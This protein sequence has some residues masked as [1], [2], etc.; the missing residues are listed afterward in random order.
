M[1]IEITKSTMKKLTL[2]VLAIFVFII[3]YSTIFAQDKKS[4]GSASS[5]E[6]LESKKE[7]SYFSLVKNL[8]ETKNIDPDQ[9]EVDLDAFIQKEKLKLQ[10]LKVPQDKQD[11]YFSTL[12]KLL[13]QAKT[14][15]Q[16][17]KELDIQI[18]KSPASFKFQDLEKKISDINVT[19]KERNLDQT[20]PLKI[21]DIVKAY[22]P[23]YMPTINDILSDETEVV[24]NQKIIALAKHLDHNPVNIFNWLR[25][26]I[27][28]E[29]YYGAKKGAVGCM[30][31]GKCNDLDTASLAI[32]M[33]RASKI[34]ARYRK[35]VA[36]I[37]IEK[38]QNLLG[39]EDK[40]AVYARFKTNKVPIFTVDGEADLNGQNLEEADLTNVTK[41]AI[42]WTYPELFYEYDYNRG[43]LDNQLSLDVLDTPE[44]RLEL[45][46]LF[47]KQWIPFETLFGGYEHI[48]NERVANTV[49][50]DFQ[51]FW[52]NFLQDQDAESP[53]E[54]YRQDLIAQ[55]NK[56]I[57]D[58]QY[59]SYRV[60]HY[61]EI[62]F[63]PYTLPYLFGEGTD[64]EGEFYDEENFSEI[65]S[66][67]KHFVEVRLRKA[68]NEEL[69]L[70]NRLESGKA[71]NATI[72]LYYSGATVTDEDTISEYNGLAHTPPSLV[73]IN[74]YMIG[75]SGPF[76][77]DEVLQIGEPLILEFSYG[78]GDE[79]LELNQKFSVAGNAE[80]IFIT[81]NDIQ[82]HW[83]YDDEEDPDRIS[84]VLIDSNAFT[85]REY[86]KELFKSQKIIDQS[87]DHY[88]NVNFARA[89]VSQN[90]SL[91]EVD[92]TP[93]TFEYNGLT[94]DASVLIN[95]TSNT[96]TF[97]ANLENMA[98]L[99]GLEGSYLEAQIFEDLTGVASISTVQ[100]LQYANNS[101]DYT[102]HIIDSNNQ[103]VIDNLEL[104]DNTKSNMQ[105][106]I[107][108]GNT[109][110]TPNRPV[111]MNDWSGILYIILRQNGTAQ[112]AIGEQ[113]H[114]GGFIT[115]IGEEFLV[116]I[117]GNLIPRYVQIN[118]RNERFSYVDSS[119]SSTNMKCS[120]SEPNYQNQI[121]LPGY[122]PEY[123]IPCIRPI[124]KYY[125]DDKEYNYVLTSDAVKFYLAGEYEYWITWRDIFSDLIAYIGR[126]Q[127]SRPSFKNISGSTNFDYLI[128]TITHESC[129][130]YDTGSSSCND[131]QGKIIYSPSNQRDKFYRIKREMFSKLSGKNFLTFVK[132][133]HPTSE[134]VRA[135]E[136][137]TGQTGTVQQFI[138]GR[139]YSTGENDVKQTYYFT[140]DAQVAFEGNGGVTGTHGFPTEDPVLRNGKWVQNFE[141]GGLEK[142]YNG[143][144]SKWTIKPVWY[145][146]EDGNHFLIIDL[147]E[148]IENRACFKGYI[149]LANDQI[150]PDHIVNNGDMYSDQTI[151][152]SSKKI[153]DVLYSEEPN[154]IFN[155]RKNLQ[156]PIA[157]VNTD[158][159]D[160]DEYT[161]PTHRYY[162]Y[163]NS[164]GL[165]L[166]FPALQISDSNK[167]SFVCTED[168]AYCKTDDGDQDPDNN[169]IFEDLDTEEYQYII[170]GGPHVIQDGLHISNLQEHYT[171]DY[172][173]GK[174]G[175][176]GFVRH[177]FG[178][179]PCDD[180]APNARSLFAIN[181][182]YAFV[183]VSDNIDWLEILPTNLNPFI[184]QYGEINHAFMF[185]GG[186]SP[187]MWYENK[188]KRSEG[189]ISPLLLIYSG[190]NA[191]N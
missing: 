53:L 97:N 12:E 24:I 145:T 170:S 147:D 181:D 42:E 61:Q 186:P 139:L 118:T 35:G 44:L 72:D 152:S 184:D 7:Y 114:N 102:V 111:T 37:E 1:R 174:K 11:K 39:V 125:Q 162:L 142:Y 127:E 122:R 48:Q 19:I 6:I 126:V 68:E 165:N 146:K 141:T 71:N 36:V 62:D 92:D 33:L 113:V 176:L 84:K 43:N 128:G 129:E 87:L 81:L 52:N 26:N 74:P 167:I 134:E 32:S 173:I 30:K 3:S 163:G 46:E 143:V 155:R 158:L 45:S 177:I 82:E 166:G 160:K 28:Y 100:G 14:G 189:P 121:N 56:D 94:L 67:R 34:P 190:Q 105:A 16:K 156:D 13:E 80:G 38:L 135:P 5:D 10:N 132:L 120:I 41:F 54:K 187:A 69:I 90:R 191:C 70:S 27:E 116:D 110:V 64:S 58:D 161:Q 149:H 119:V 75:S 137:L 175:I 157:A 66:A 151:F 108:S 4:I 150:I 95:N 123:G 50:F 99:W 93:T 182:Q 29:P 2:F 101:D 23:E 178:K 164:Y 148:E 31:E 117:N 179:N 8:T 172:L 115:E 185:D 104:S 103:S 55:T 138:N 76:F 18:P 78:I 106:A 73:D 88:T 188:I 91:N 133:G 63:I 85:A 21:F 183:I 153:E 60:R 79:E 77:S 59:K 17:S 107:Q 51:S 130:N 25:E 140:H 180:S 98:L 89:V 154:H 168:T 109:V 96:D 9:L 112:Y 49:N 47:K 171:C 144:E 136:S 15:E 22:G 159:Y 83:S 20:K 131:G 57:L 124:S 40:K 169:K 86:M 65:P